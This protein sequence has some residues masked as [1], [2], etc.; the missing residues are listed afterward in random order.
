MNSFAEETAEAFL[1]SVSAAVNATNYRGTLI[2]SVSGRMDSM[3]LLHSNEDG[4]IREKLTAMDGEG[5]EII[6]SGN[7]LVWILPHRRI[8]LV[9]TNSTP[10]NAFVRLQAANA[11]LGDLYSLEAH[12]SDRV[13]GRKALRYFVRPRDGYRYGHKFW[14]D[15]ATSLPLRMQLVD[16]KRVI[17]EIRFV[18][19]E[20][21]VDFVGGDFDS[22]IDSADFHVIQAG[23]SAASMAANSN[24]EVGDAA[25]TADGTEWS[26]KE[27]ALGF[28][29]NDDQV[30]TVE[31]NGRKSR[32]FVFS[33]GL[34]SVS[35]FIEQ[36]PSGNVAMSS[37]LGK[38]GA[39]HTYQ[40]NVGGRVLTVVGEVPAETLRMLAERTEQQ[41]LSNQE[42]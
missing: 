37:Q 27:M 23:T 39:S 8:K 1:D 10:S 40:R 26:P 20:I 35:V 18:S 14:I 15:A 12:G 21:G 32:R 2:R 30:Q 33:D 29:L 34:V 19:I 6:R 22:D 9:D 42:Q 38:M 4:F 28:R 16:G 41:L 31:I 5:R 25:R 13:A 36:R 7:E 17:E 11:A 3:E 24:G